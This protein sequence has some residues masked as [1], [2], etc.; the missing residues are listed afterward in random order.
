MNN[1][2]ERAVLAALSISVWPATRTDREVSEE[3]A[4]NH[5]V[6][7]KRAGHYRKHCIDVKAAE[8]VAVTQAATA[9]RAVHAKF[10]LPW[11]DGGARILPAGAFLDYRDA[12]A[13]GRDV[14][15]D[16]V[17][18]FE[19]AWPRLVAEA[20]WTLNGLWRAE[21]YPAHPGDLFGVRTALFPFPDVA[22]FRVSMGASERAAVR[23]EMQATL[24]ESVGAA[25]RE[26]F[27]RLQAHVARMAERLSDPKA[28]F[29]D[30][31]VEGLVELC[32]VLP[33]L[34][35]TGDARLEEAVAKARDMVAGICA[36]DLR[37]DAATRAH[38]AAQSS[39]LDATLQGYL[40]RVAP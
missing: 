18:D 32:D 34:N 37:D 36:Q 5:A 1:L 39:E 13:Q 26:P 17:R 11:A 28:V 10:T 29:R 4:R 25:M 27:E 15:N 16:A 9:L 31:L 33:R 40:G 7:A 30:S 20:R 14:F 21:D 2:S 38:V 12:V 3:V 23:A 22:D 19:T 8:Y 35:I 6:S 24:Q